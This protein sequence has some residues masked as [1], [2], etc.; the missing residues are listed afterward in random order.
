M[1]FLN[2]FGRPA[3]A[4]A[5]SDSSA[6]SAASASSASSAASAGWQEHNVDGV[7][8]YLNTT[9]G[10]ISMTPPATRSSDADL[11]PGWVSKP[12]I[13][14][15]TYYVGPIWDF[16]E[17]KNKMYLQHERPTWRGMPAAIRLSP[18]WK[19]FFTN[20]KSRMHGEPSVI[21]ENIETHEKTSNF[22]LASGDDLRKILADESAQ[23]SS[24][25][26]YTSGHHGG[27]N[28]RKQS[29]RKQRKRNATRRRMM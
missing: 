10:E 14:G 8:M 22:P 4:S 11:P 21:Y 23:A 24:E 3:A 15:N 29:K 6:S 18:T 28:K 13:K 7:I 12:D 20:D 26:W 1:N 25:P 16:I 5:S 27:K 2:F 9:T 17:N 19:V